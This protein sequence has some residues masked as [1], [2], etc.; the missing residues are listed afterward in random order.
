MNDIEYIEAKQSIYIYM[1]NVCNVAQ[2][3]FRRVFSHVFHLFTGFGVYVCVVLCAE[4]VQQH[5][6]NLKRINAH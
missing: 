3:Q 2:L 6:I 4:N 1:K 5:F